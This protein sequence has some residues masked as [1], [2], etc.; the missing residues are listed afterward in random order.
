MNAGYR[1]GA[2]SY[3]CSTGNGSKHEA[4]EFDAFAALAVAGLRGLPDALA[5]RAIIIRMRRRAPDE[6]VE[7]F[8]IKYHV[9]QAAP[10]KQALEEW[11]S[12]AAIS[13]EPVMPP[14]VVDRA[15]DIWEPLIAIADAYGGEWPEMGRAAAVFFTKANAEDEARSSGVELLSH[16]REAF[17]ADNQL[18]S[19]VLIERLCSRDES[20]WATANRGNPIDEMGLAKRLKHYSIK[21]GKLRIGGQTPRGYHAD[22]FRDAWGRY[23]PPDPE[24]PEHPEH[25]SHCNNL[26]VPPVP[27]VPPNEGAG[28]AIEGEAGNDWSEQIGFDDS[29]DTAPAGLPGSRQ[30]HAAKGRG[31]EKLGLCRGEQQGPGSAPHEPRDEHGHA[32]TTALASTAR[33]ETDA[34][35]GLRV[36]PACAAEGWTECCH[37]QITPDQI[38]RFEQLRARFDAL[39]KPRA[40]AAA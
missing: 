35:S 21:P 4:L 32:R 18:P 20:P 2:R 23:L 40:E 7:P 24:H 27:P 30:R 38:E 15:A 33:A 37:S 12:G 39:P 1:R 3:R 10:I 11:C 17:R 8:R 16:I 6:E 13:Q 5:T 9:P 31:E 29:G 22:D 26:N 28:A 34:G 14:G 19:K 25:L 36:C